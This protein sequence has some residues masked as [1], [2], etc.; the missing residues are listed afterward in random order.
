MGTV[1]SI[2]V[3][4]VSTEFAA[5][6]IAAACRWLHWV[7]ATFSTYRPESEI[8]RIARGE[9]ALA[10]AAP[11]VRSVLA[12]CEQ[13]HQETGGAFDAYA[14]GSLDPRRS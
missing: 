8:C 13:L 6:G 1:A 9:L 12:R 10:D 11:E 2:D 3:R 4:G 7:D 5:T 14:T